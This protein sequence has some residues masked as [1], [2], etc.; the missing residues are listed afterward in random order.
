[1]SRLALGSSLFRA[2]CFRLDLAGSGGG[3]SRGHSLGRVGQ[4]SL[5]AG[6]RAWCVR[7]SLHCTDCHC[8]RSDR[9]IRT[10]F[11]HSLRKWAKI[12]ADKLTYTRRRVRG[13]RY[14]FAA[15]K[16]PN[17]VEHVVSKHFSTSLIGQYIGIRSEDAFTKSDLFVSLHSRRVHR[18]R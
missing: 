11:V 16:Q 10:G 7:N 17:T 14:V 18:L 6:G 2:L 12:G 4:A 1:M 5:R 9:N 15:R 3:A 13:N 8:T